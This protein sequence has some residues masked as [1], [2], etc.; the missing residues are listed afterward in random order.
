MVTYPL[1]L[2]QVLMRLE[3]NEK[4]FELTDGDRGGGNGG[5]DISSASSIDQNKQ[6]GKGYNGTLDCIMDLWK[7]GGMKALYSG[8]DA[9]LIQAVLTSALTFLTY[10]QLLTIVARSYW[11]F[12]N[13][14][15]SGTNAI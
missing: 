6:C 8:M 11:L 13:R 12:S 1:Q 10:E 7:R 14:L 3:K 2:A 15:D 9:K 5:E 4:E